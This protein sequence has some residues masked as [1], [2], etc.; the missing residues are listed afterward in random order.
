MCR[1]INVPNS[2]WGQYWLLYPLHL[3]NG[4]TITT[5]KVFIADYNADSGGTMFVHMVSRPWNS[6]QSG[7]DFAG[8]IGTSAGAAGDQMISRTGISTVVD[9]ETKAYW[10]EMTPVNSANPGELC[11]YGIQVTYTYNGALLPLVVR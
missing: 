4:V 5:V 8:S 7:S 10:I 6:R 9:N 3:P 2:T 1:Y 11:V